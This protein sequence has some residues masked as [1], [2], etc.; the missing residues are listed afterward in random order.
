MATWSKMSTVPNPYTD[1]N[2][3]PYSGAVLKVYDPGTS[4]TQ[5][6]AITSAGGSQQGTIAYNAS[7]ALEVSGNARAASRL[8]STPC[9]WR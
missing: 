8:S 9:Y 7:G 6:I 1:S 2:G 4:N 5:S 3:N